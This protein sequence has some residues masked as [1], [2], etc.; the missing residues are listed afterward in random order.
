MENVR[1][2]NIKMNY[3]FCPYCKGG[4]IKNNFVYKCSECGK[5]IFIN[6]APCVSVIPI[7]DNK[8]LLSIR[9]IEPKKG[10]YDFVGGFVNV[11]ETIGECGIRET[12][13]ETGLKIKLDKF[14]GE[15]N[16]TY[17][18]GVTYPLTFNYT[19]KIIGGVLKA[20]DDV[21]ELVWIDIN[22]IESLDL[23]KSFKSIKI[24]LDRLLTTL[25]RGAGN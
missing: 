22:D 17:I 2:M 7:K 5:E 14:L 13:E 3:K 19:A 4:L 9:G 12:E 6:P 24:V 11:G 1:I 23:T 10:T 20:N 16:E 8:I 21:A 15:C 18:P 25:G